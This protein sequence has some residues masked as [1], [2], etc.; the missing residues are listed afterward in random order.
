VAASGWIGSWFGNTQDPGSAYADSWLAS[1]LPRT[2][3]MLMKDPTPS[4][5]LPASTSCSA[6]DPVQ[7]MFQLTKPG[8]EKGDADAQYLLGL[9]YATGQGVEKDYAE[10]IR[11]YRK[12]AD[13]GLASAQ[14]NLGV[15]YD[16]GQ[17]VEKDYV[18]AYA[19]LNLAAKTAADAP[20]ARDDLEARMTSQQVADA[21]KRTTELLARIEAK[22]S[23]RTK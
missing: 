21:R 18:E 2:Y 12:A 9:F 11:W 16:I 20:E 14:L 17:G 22:T 4:V 6:E 5:A 23:G 1:R 7:K 3:S 13:Q 10:A 8:A 15:A 19:W